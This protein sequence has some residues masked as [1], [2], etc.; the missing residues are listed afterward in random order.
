MLETLA[1]PA[2]ALASTIAAMPA[3]AIRRGKRNEG[4]TYNI[5]MELSVNELFIRCNNAGFP[6]SEI[7]SKVVNASIPGTLTVEFLVNTF[8]SSDDEPQ[9]RTSLIA[10]SGMVYDAT[11]DKS[12]LEHSFEDCQSRNDCKTCG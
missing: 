12:F 7:R 9:V 4:P 2:S 5:P 10:I 11:I 6:G 8:P 1:F 3:V